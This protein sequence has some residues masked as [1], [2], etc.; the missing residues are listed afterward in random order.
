VV[1][2]LRAWLSSI[3]VPDVTPECSCG[4][5]RRTIQH[6]LGFCPDHIEARNKLLERTGHTQIDRLLCEK[7]TARW[8]E[9][10]LLDTGLLDYLQ[11][12][13]KV[14]A[15]DT[16]DWAPFTN[17]QELPYFPAA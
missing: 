12:A 14:E 2:G 15:T 7:D 10:W 8:A 17:S 1:L 3:G 16:G 13:L 9:Q 5:P 11:V 4:H 6:V